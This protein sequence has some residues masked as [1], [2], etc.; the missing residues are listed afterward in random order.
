MSDIAEIFKMKDGKI[1][2]R[3]KKDRFACYYSS[4]EVFVEMINNK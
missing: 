3:F 4:V 1:W 2:Y